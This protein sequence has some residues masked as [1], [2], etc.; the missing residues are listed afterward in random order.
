MA[1]SQSPDLVSQIPEPSFTKL[2]AHSRA[3]L[4][5]CHLNIIEHYLQQLL[6]EGMSLL[7]NG[8]MGL[9]GHRDNLVYAKG[10]DLLR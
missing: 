1:T 8:G 9:V 10:R 7:L 6:T 4:L 5:C 2:S 3:V